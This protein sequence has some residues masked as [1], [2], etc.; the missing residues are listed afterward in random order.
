MKLRGSIGWPGSS[1]LNFITYMQDSS[2][3]PKHLI[4]Q[5]MLSKQGELLVHFSHN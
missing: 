5:I 3:F 2:G 4:S 1:Y